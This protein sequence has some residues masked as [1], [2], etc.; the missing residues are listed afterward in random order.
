MTSAKAEAVRVIG[1]NAVIL[2][3]TAVDSTGAPYGV[4]MTSTS[5]EALSAGN[6]EFTMSGGSLTSHSGD[7]IVVTK[8][9]S[10]SP[11]TP[12]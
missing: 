1:T 10:I 2:S 8:Q 11:I 9:P 5:K 12:Q 6:A 3:Q 7:G 4:L